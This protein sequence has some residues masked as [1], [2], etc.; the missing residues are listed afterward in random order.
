MGRHRQSRVRPRYGRISAAASAMAVTVVAVLGSTGVL[1][2][3]A[4]HELDRPASAGAASAGALSAG[5]ASS[6]VVEDPA[7]R[8]SEVAPEAQDAPEPRE[9]V[10]SPAALV[11][12]QP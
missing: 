2:S 4:S 11:K 7:G 12:R 9:P 3:A 10:A 6:T 8:G 5:A 1:T